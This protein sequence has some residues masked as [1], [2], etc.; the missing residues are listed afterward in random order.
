LCNE[1][2]DTACILTYLLKNT[3]FLTYWIKPSIW[4]DLLKIR[5]NLS[6]YAQYLMWVISNHKHHQCTRYML[7]KNCSESMN[8][9]YT[10]ERNSQEYSNGG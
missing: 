9:A 6:N 5:K 3:H 1:A 2:E 7:I 4:Y 8:K 10:S